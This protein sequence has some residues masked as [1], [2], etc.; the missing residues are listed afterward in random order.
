MNAVDLNTQGPS[1]SEIRDA[2]SALEGRIVRTPTVALNSDRIRHRFA[3]G[4]SPILKL[5]LFQQTG[6]FKAR[7]ALLALDALDDE[8]R[9]RGVTAVSAGNHALAVAWAAGRA[10]VSA[11]VV[12]PETADP[13]RVEGCRA[14][15]AEVVLEENT[16]AAFARMDRIV[17]EEGRVVIHPFEGRFPTL[18]TATCGLE[19]IEDHRDLE[20]VI[21]PVGGGGLVSGIARACKLL[22]PGCAV[23]GVEPFGADSLFRS[24][25]AGKPVALPRVDTVADSLGAPM[26]LPYS[27]AVARANVDEIVRVGDEDM[28]EAMTWLY[29]ALKLAP[30]PACAAATAA[31]AGPLRERLA[32]K[33]VGLIACGSNIGELKFGELMARGRAVDR[34][35]S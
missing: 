7:G 22:S 9:R 21:V 27:F 26:A 4:P 32:G 29:D 8:G 24:F 16:H 20:A 31:L 15:G 25:E 2:A 14:M 19:L 3:D 35:C 30:E 33:R 28:L 23:F 5:E 11:K 18:G 13:V 34:A 12:M 17:A 6:S 1:L 10:G